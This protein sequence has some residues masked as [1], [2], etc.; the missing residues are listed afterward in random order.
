MIR[1]DYFCQMAHI[2]STILVGTMRRQVILFLVLLSASASAVCAG[3]W[4]DKDYRCMRKVSVVKQYGR[5]PGD[6][7]AL[8]RFATNGLLKPD[9]SDIRV[10]CGGKLVPY[11]IVR[12][13]PGDQI[14]LMFKV[15]YNDRE[16]YEIYYGNPKAAK[17]DFAWE[18]KRGLTL[19]TR[20]YRGGGFNNWR[21]MQVALHRSK[22]Y[23]YG[24]DLVGQVYHG[25]NPFGPSRN[26]VSVYKGWIW[27]RR[28]GKYDFMTSSASASFLHVDDKMV[29]Q[30]PG[31]HRAVAD[32]RRHKVISLK[33]GI[34]TFAYYH[35]QGGANPIMVAAWRPDGR[36]RAQPIEPETFLP[37]LKTVLEEYRH[38]NEDFAIGFDWR[39]SAET[40][41]DKS[42]VVTLRFYDRSF[43][44]SSAKSR[45]EWDFGDGTTS[46]E[47]SPAHTFLL[48]GDYTVTL[49][50]FRGGKTYEC[51]QKVHVAENWAKQHLERPE[52]PK[53]AV[54]RIKG[55]DFDALSA[56]AL[57]GALLLFRKVENSKDF[58]LAGKVLIRKL[59]EL[60][61]AEMVEA[62]ILLATA[63]RDEA[64]SP[65]MAVRILALAERKLKGANNRARVAV[66]AGD[67]KFFQLESPTTAKAVYEHVIKDYA[68]STEYVR[69]STMRLGDIARQLGQTAE[70]RYHYRKAA[71]KKPKSTPGRE[72]MTRALRA[73]ETEDLLRRRDLD[74]A[75][76]KLHLWQW[77]EPED[78]L[79]GHWS[80]LMVRLSVSRKKWKEAIREGDI[81]VRANPESQYVPAILMDMATAY[82][83][84][85]KP[86]Q[87]RASLE[88]VIKEY[89]DSPLVDAAKAK[90]GK[91]K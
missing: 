91:I 19:E 38:Y 25:H 88:R 50:S 59:P 49:K 34:H 18:P 12:R 89:A 64:K 77:Q 6:E 58:M 23:S 32:G 55:Y 82:Q 4:W 44:H 40:V 62:A 75:E 56:R 31:W 74:A 85:K 26:F 28:A 21:Q 47:F 76:E 11:K 51:K 41:L 2:Q 60:P 78:K 43:P 45:R 20:R 86:A 30:W 52:K 71:L 68:K 81:L 29:V 80:A 83:A 69:M 79:H 73:L 36:K 33:A 16:K 65:G 53:Q 66:M 10:V 63:W 70:A 3:S 67:I 7:A 22:K 37:P 46:K 84:M 87:T 35:A 17:A 15:D 8:V 9:V 42:A 5:R 57:Y 90:L 48:T 1:D 13:G 24:R 61:E 72:A 27:V 54:R 14:A 39:N